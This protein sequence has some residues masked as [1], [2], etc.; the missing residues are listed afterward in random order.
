M[1]LDSPCPHGQLSDY[2]YGEL[3]VRQ[4]RDVDPA[5]AERLAVLAQQEVEQ[6][7]QLY[8]EMATRGP[9]RFP[10]GARPGR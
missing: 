7:W 10:A 6:R 8:E 3:R 1:L 4:L 9:E 5:G 2:T